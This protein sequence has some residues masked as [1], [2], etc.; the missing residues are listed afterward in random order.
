VPKPYGTF[1]LESMDS[2][3]AWISTATD[4]VK[5]ASAFDDYEKCPLLKPVT[6][7]TMFARPG[8]LAGFDEKGN[9]KNEFYGCGWRVFPEGDGKGSANHAGAL[10]GTST[11]MLHRNDGINMAV[12]FNYRSTIDRKPLS[13][14]IMPLLH[15]AANEIREWPEGASEA[16]SK[17]SADAAR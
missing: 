5:F 8:G 10:D 14:V 3:G 15:K 12:L 9:P 4:L 16:D 1:Y 11:L 17:K 2:H 6:I 7:A 13:T